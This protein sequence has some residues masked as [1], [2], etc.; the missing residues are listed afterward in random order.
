MINNDSDEKTTTQHDHLVLYNFNEHIVKLSELYCACQKGDV[1]RSR[2]L[3]STIP[4]HKRIW[5]LEPNG[6]T[7]LHAAVRAG[8]ASIVTLLFTHGFSRISINKENKTAYEIASNND[9]RSLFHRSID[10]SQSRFIDQNINQ[11]LKI[12]DLNYN[13]HDQVVYDNINDAIESRYMAVF[14]R[15][16]RFLKNIVRTMTEAKSLQIF[17]MIVAKVQNTYITGTDDQI[18]LKNTFDD[19]VRTKDINHLIHL[20]TLNDLYKAIREHA[21]AY[22]TLVCLNLSLLSERK[23]QGICYRGVGMTIHDVSRFYYAMKTSSSV[24]ETRN[25]S[26]TSK[27][28]I[29]SSIY[30]GFGASRLDNL[31]SVLLVFEFSKPCS[32]AIDLTR[33]SDRLPTISQF[34]HEEE[35]LI[36][37]YTLFKVTRVTEETDIEPFS[38]YLQNVTVPKQSLINFFRMK[39]EDIK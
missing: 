31:Y 9:I 1:N 15:M 13:T 20:Y 17:K 26:S 24:I 22:T 14:N 30:S 11:T 38:I 33:V 16:P 19:F 8:H 36:L 29:V 5:K 10:E 27:N 32:T 35:V 21:N 23:Y 6:D 25:L 7:A 12:L 2:E 39:P 4:Y 34:E 18:L 37:P 3:L 28:K